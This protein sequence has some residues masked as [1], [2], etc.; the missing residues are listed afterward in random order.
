MWS[1]I[2]ATAEISDPRIWGRQLSAYASLWR[3]TNHQPEMILMISKVSRPYDKLMKALQG[4][5]LPYPPNADREMKKG[6][7]LVRS[8]AGG[9]LMYLAQHCPSSIYPGFEEL[10]NYYFQSIDLPE[11]RER[12]AWLLLNV[13]L[14]VKLAPF[15][16]E[17]M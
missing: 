16:P 8:R 14:I 9:S 11:T 12:M 3:Y 7:R 6:Y 13:L 17:L 1:K 10:W 4:I 5:N 2:I 15:F